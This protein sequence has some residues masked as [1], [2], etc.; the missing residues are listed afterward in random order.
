M[1]GPN[2]DTVNSSPRLRECYG[3]EGGKTEGRGWEDC[4]EIMSFGY[5][6]EVPKHDV[7]G[8]PMSSV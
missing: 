3:R 2:K 1:L 7:E 4:C 8:A 6:V 5:D